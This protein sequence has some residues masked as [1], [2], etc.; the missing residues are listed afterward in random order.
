MLKV[1]TSRLAPDGSAGP[2]GKS[3]TGPLDAM[4]RAASKAGAAMSEPGTD[5]KEKSEIASAASGADSAAS[6]P[7]GA[8]GSTGGTGH[9]PGANG[10]CFMA[11]GAHAQ[12]MC[13]GVDTV[14]H[15]ST[16]LMCKGHR[17]RR[18]LTYI[19]SS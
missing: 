6:Q 9:V 14:R 12:K 18:H 8:A 4:L 13:A 11:W 17:F 2:G 10:V 19:F 7:T 16:L 1:V 5:A 15:P 3:A